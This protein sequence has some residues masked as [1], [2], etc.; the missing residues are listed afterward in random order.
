MNLENGVVRL[1]EVTIKNLKNVEMGKISLQSYNS[2]KKRLKGLEENSSTDILGIY[3]QNGSGKT[4]L[5]DAISILELLLLGKKIPNDIKHLINNDSI[6][7][8]LNFKFLLE[9]INEDIL[10]D[11]SVVFIKIERVLETGEKETIV[12]IKKENLE[13]STISKYNKKSRP[14]KIISYDITDNAI[15]PLN[16]Y[17]QI[18]EKDKNNLINLG[19]AKALSIEERTSFIF[20]KRSLDI[21]K[22][23]FL[24]NINYKVLDSLTN[25]ARLNLFVIKSEQLGAIN[26]NR[27]L[28]F[29]FRLEND[30]RIISGGY[31]ALFEKSFLNEEFYN[32]LK[33]IIKQTNIVINAVIPGLEINI[34]EYGKQLDENGELKVEVELISIRENKKIPLK[35][36][37]DGIKK[38]ISIL[39]ALIAMYNNSSICLVVDELDAGIFEYLLGELL[40]ILEERAKGQFIFTS[41]NLRALEKLNKE[42]IIFTTVNPKNRYIKLSNV[43]SNNNLRDFYYR[44][45]A[46]GGQKEELYNET[47][48]FEMNYAFRKAGEILNENK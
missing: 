46:L 30:S 32:I 1:Q 45:I 9:D 18:I 6:N 3:G 25:F 17:N 48:A 27:L 42:S 28:P 21:F 39:S 41:H 33:K 8:E 16:V 4:T 22:K 7:A 10:I 26:M 37:S 23:S 44:M 15:K 35:Y 31:V 24:E 20:N 12:N 29:S 36:E 34:E 13:Y 38:I 47:D 19:V 11:Y 2:L 40:D 14:K 43:K 5:V